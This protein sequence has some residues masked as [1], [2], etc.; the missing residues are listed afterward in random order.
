MLF[1]SVGRVRESMSGTLK[2]WTIYKSTRETFAILICFP[3]VITLFVKIGDW[4]Y[5]FAR[6]GDPFVQQYFLFVILL[7][8]YVYYLLKKLYRDWLLFYG[9]GLSTLGIAQILYFFRYPEENLANGNIDYFYALLLFIPC[10]ILMI[11]L[12]V[13]IKQQDFATIKNSSVERIISMIGLIITFVLMFA[14]FLPWERNILKATSETWKF[15]GS[16]TNTLIE[17]CCYVTE[18]GI[19][20]SLQIYIP[21]IGLGFLFLSSTLGYRISTFSFVPNVVWCVQESIDFLTNLGVQDPLDTWTKAEVDANGLSRTSEGIFGGYLFVIATFLLLL[22]ML[23]PR[24]L[25][26]KKDDSPLQI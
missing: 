26:G 11:S 4:D 20:G 13:I 8:V 19:N 14:E 15:N 1:R 24:V 22:I 21:L 3:L 10:I 2:E 12:V 16:G 5:L 7:L 6:I 18:Y 17:E 23:I 9:L 25:S